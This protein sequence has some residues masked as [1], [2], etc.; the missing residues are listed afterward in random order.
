MTTEK[1]TLYDYS[2]ATEFL[3]T[4][5]TLIK[6]ARSLYHQT[7]HQELP[8]DA[9]TRLMLLSELEERGLLLAKLKVTVLHALDLRAL[10]IVL[11]AI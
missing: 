5:E 1:I 4:I 2:D 9:D 10:P 7:S 11:D 3:I 6:A 8:I